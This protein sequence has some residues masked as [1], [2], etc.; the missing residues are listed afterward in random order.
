MS[1]RG[2]HYMYTLMAATADD[3]CMHS[4]TRICLHDPCAAAGRG[5]YRYIHSVP[6]YL[7]GTSKCIL[8][9]VFCSYS[10]YI[11]YAVY[12]I[13]RERIEVPVLL[14]YM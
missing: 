7:P 4:A 14:L 12:Y 9:S 13:A 11:V 6:L 5:G 8:Y 1:A 3:S 2:A 10:I